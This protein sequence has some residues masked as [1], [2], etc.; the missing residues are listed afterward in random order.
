MN[1]MQV[2]KQRWQKVFGTGTGS[3]RPIPGDTSH[4]TI[5]YVEDITVSFDGFRALNKLTL[6]IDVGE[7]RSPSLPRYSDE[8]ITRQPVV[9]FPFSAD[10]RR[11]G[12]TR[13]VGIADEHGV[14]RRERDPPAA[15][16]PAWRRHE[17]ATHPQRRFPVHQIVDTELL[18][19]PA[20]DDR[21]QAAAS[22][23]HGER[24]VGVRRNGKR[25]DA[26]LRRPN[27]GPDG[28]NL[29]V[30]GHERA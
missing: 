15:R 25:I 28:V 18:S 19:L 26:T 29:P 13:V 3:D 20:I 21:R 27:E 22:G 8:T 7:L 17:W 2:V 6:Y 1:A 23:L 24:E 16:A 9:D 11:R 5:L 10:E 12:W 30:G 14:A 4:G